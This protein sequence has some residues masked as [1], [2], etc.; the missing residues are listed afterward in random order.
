MT[1][2]SSR[3]F[4]FV[5]WL[6]H[7]AVAALLVLTAPAPVAGQEADELIEDIAGPPR[8]L[9]G[10]GGFIY[11]GEGDIDG[12][13]SVEV[14]RFDVGLLGTAKLSERW[15]WR[16]A[17]FFGVHGYDF[18]GAGFGAGD[19]WDTT[20]NMRL[21]S[22]LSY[23]INDTWGVS[24]GGIFIFSPETDADWGDS[25]T[26]GGTLGVEYRHSDTLF[27]SLGVAVISQI[28]DDATVVPMV[29]VNWQP[30]P[31]WTLRVGAVPASGGAAAAG[32]LAYRVLE[33]L[34]IGLGA[35]YHQR[36]FRLD[37]SG[38][39]R[40][41]VGVDD[42]LPIRLRLGWDITQHV[43]LHLLGGVVVAGEVEL[44]DRNGNRLRKEDYDPA[45]Y[46]GLRLLG[47]L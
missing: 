45:A 34:E 11:Q 7:A 39:A 9:L 47:H 19:P 37:N 8:V 46:V 17:Y 14:M 33:P 26:G 38:P 29:G 40:Q 1:T 36:R 23:A 3:P 13:G 28:E 21:G 27:A 43:S 16:N 35:I 12:G 41:G 30:D 6:L 24:A 32:E 20:L 31:L 18:D 10:E 5:A 22:A 2:D 42:N 15:R 4:A 44:E 25:F